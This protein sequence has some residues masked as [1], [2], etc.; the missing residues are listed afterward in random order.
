MHAYALENCLDPIK[1]I[2][3]FVMWVKSYSFHWLLNQVSLEDSWSSM[4]DPMFF[5]HGSPSKYIIFQ[6][7]NFSI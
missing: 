4:L 5:D 3:E 2:F 6:W 1:D 7:D